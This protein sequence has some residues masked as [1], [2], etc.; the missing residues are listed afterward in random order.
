MK[1][2]TV[3]LIGVASALAAVSSVYSQIQ[4]TTDANT[5]ALYHLNE[6]SGST[7]FDSSGNNWN[8][9]I[10]STVSK[11][12]PSQPG[13]YTS[14]KTAASLSTGRISYLDTS[15]TNGQQSELYT[16][17][18]TAFTLEAWIKFD[19]LEFTSNVMIAAVQPFQ[20][21]VYDYRLGVLGS[22]GA[23]PYAL[24][25][26]TGSTPNMAF[27][28]GG[29]SWTVDQW[30][31]VAVTVENTGPGASDTVIKLYRNVAGDST[32]PSPIYTTTR[33][34]LVLNTSSTAQR[35]L[36]IGNYYG[37]NGA[38]YFPG[39]IDEVRVSNIARTEFS[40]LAIPETSTTA[41]LGIGAV[42]L[43][44]VIRKRKATV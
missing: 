30:Y 15:T 14:M 39:S 37:A 31:H 32:T 35:Q 40:T 42:L 22:G 28:L 24:T 3:A 1:N 29:L 4:Y 36:E 27:P 19:S 33:G 5:V 41:M 17:A 25:F 12:R 16:M 7:A 21:V 2:K 34:D 8:A 20:N 9:T 26:G 10:G 13:L 11:G 38:Y 23:N 44:L 18:S 43:F 6:T